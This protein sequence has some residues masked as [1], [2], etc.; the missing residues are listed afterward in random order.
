[1]YQLILGMIFL[2]LSCTTVH[3]RSG[4]AGNNQIEGIPRL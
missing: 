1:M 4:N 3:N 2:W